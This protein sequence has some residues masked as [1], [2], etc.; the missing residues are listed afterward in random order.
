MSQIVFFLTE[1][2]FIQTVAVLWYHSLSFAHIK[3][4]TKTSLKKP[5]VLTGFAY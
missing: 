4:N 1:S 2:D 3:K 5:V